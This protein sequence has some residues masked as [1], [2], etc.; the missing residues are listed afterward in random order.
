VTVTVTAPVSAG[1]DDAA[2]VCG[3]GAPFTLADSLGGTPQGNGQWLT[4]SLAPHGP[5][6]DPATDAPGIWTYIVGAGGACPDSALLAVAVQAPPAQISGDAD[7]CEGEST[8]LTGS[9]GV[10]YAWSPTTGL[11]Q[12]AAAATSA[13]PPGTITYTLT[14]TD[15]LGCT[16][17]ASLTVVVHALPAV[18]AGPDRSYCAGGS[19]IIG[20]TPTAAPGAAIAWTPGT[21]LSSTTSGNPTAAPV[22]TT[23]YTVTVTDANQCSSIDQVTVTVNP[24]PVVDAG[25]DAAICLG[26]TVQLQAS[27]T[28]TFAWSPSDGLSNAGIGDPMADP[29]STTTYTV[30]LTDAN[31]CSA[32]DGLTITVNPL[33]TAQAGTDSWLC[34]G[35]STTLVGSGT[36]PFFDWS[37]TNGLS[38]PAS[39]ST[40]AAPATSTVYTLTVTDANGCQASDAVSIAVGTDPPIDAGPSSTICSGTGVILGG[41]P[42][43]V[44]GSTYLWSPPTGLSDATSPNP[45][46]SPTGTQTYY[47]VVS[48]DT[49]TSSA[50][51]TVNVG[52]TGHAD[53]S[54]RFE[55]GCEALRGF[56]T[57]AS[58]GAV[59]WHW[60]FGTGATSTSSNPQA[61]LPYG[62][63]TEV[64]LV[65]TDAGGCTDT[66]R[67]TFTMD[68]YADLAHVDVPNVFTPNGDGQ[69]DNFTLMTQAFLGPCTDMEVMNRWGERVFVSQ[70]NNITWDGRNF[71]GEACSPGTY[72][73][74]IQVKDLSFKGTVTLVR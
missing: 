7:L 2:L 72:F 63:A 39:A 50:S 40:Q 16:G 46:A 74:V 43:S 64:V 52:T 20:G 44:P 65:I 24:L 6:F 69:N 45:I 57:D 68:S 4:P 48:N 35:S 58:I 56:F 31:G 33:P 42:T 30:T 10:S 27:G 11:A 13:T 14:V 54:A 38:S 17:T 59:A 62:E 34:L 5:L 49:C 71:A 67:T 51:V 73:Y 28:G 61:Y 60:E 26:N 70:G 19:A 18:D 55:P 36:G 53:F 1:T 3:S 32:S 23:Q 12:P 22:A 8:M 37:P 15:A 21:G 47:L 66:A 29:T 41:S 25:A 9:G